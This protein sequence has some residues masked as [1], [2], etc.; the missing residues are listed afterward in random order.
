MGRAIGGSLLLYGAACALPIAIDRVFDMPM[1]G[2]FA[3]VLGWYGLGEGLGG[4]AWLA[5]WTWAASLFALAFRHFQVALA[6]AALSFAFGLFAP[7]LIGT[8]HVGYLAWLGSFAVVAVAAM[9][10]DTDRPPRP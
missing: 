6:L 1:A 10:L 8:P 7:L 9:R 2:I 4:I 3:L 5:N